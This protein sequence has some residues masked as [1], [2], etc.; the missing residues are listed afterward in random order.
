MEFTGVAH[1]KVPAGGLACVKRVSPPK[2]LYS[3]ITR[4]LAQKPESVRRWLQAMP[5]SFCTDVSFAPPG[6]VGFHLVYPRL[7][8]WAAFCR[9]FAA[10]PPSTRARRQRFHPNFFLWTGAGMSGWDAGALRWSFL[11]PLRAGCFLWF[12]FPRLAPW[13]A[14][15]RRFAAGNVPHDNIS[16]DQVQ[17]SCITRRR[18]W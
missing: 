8:P 5:T 15:F 13:A 10:G 16:R 1:R 11:S 3:G 17:G 12:Q 14:F 18:A 4:I 7:A 6:L 9:R 2:P